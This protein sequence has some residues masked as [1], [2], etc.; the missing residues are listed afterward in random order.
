MALLDL[1]CPTF[2]DG[3]PTRSAGKGSRRS[4]RNKVMQIDLHQRQIRE[5]WCRNLPPTLVTRVDLP[6]ESGLIFGI[7]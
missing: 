7:D 4:A 2:S 3:W 6:I 1:V 5:H